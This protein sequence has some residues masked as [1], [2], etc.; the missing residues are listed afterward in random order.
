MNDVDLRT[1]YFV[2]AVG[3]LV[4]MQDVECVFGLVVREVRHLGRLSAGAQEGLG[5]GE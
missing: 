1:G 5:P 4:R 2:F 3:G